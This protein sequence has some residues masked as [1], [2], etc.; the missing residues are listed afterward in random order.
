[1]DYWLFFVVFFLTGTKSNFDQ[2]G[3]VGNRK[4]HV[5][6]SSCNSQV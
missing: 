6:D 3:E 5:K 4:C 1:M 2:N